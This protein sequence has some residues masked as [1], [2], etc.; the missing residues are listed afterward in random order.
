MKRATLLGLM[1]A[2]GALLSAQNNIPEILGKEKTGSTTLDVLSKC[3]V[4]LSKM[5]QPDDGFFL[6]TSTRQFGWSGAPIDLELAQQIHYPKLAPSGQVIEYIALKGAADGTAVGNP[7]EISV[8]SDIGGVPGALLATD[9]VECADNIVYSTSEAFNAPL[10][11]GQDLWISYVY[12]SD[13]MG[14]PGPRWFWG[15]TD[16]LTNLANGHPPFHVTFVD[17]AAPRF[18]PNC[19]QWTNYVYCDLY[20]ALRLFFIGNTAGLNYEF[21]ICRN[22]KLNIGTGV[23]TMTQWG[24]FIFGLV[25]LTLGVVALYNYQRKPGQESSL[26]TSRS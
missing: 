16:R 19:P 12:I 7:G 10:T 11:P 3:D 26:A 15:Q 25:V 18:G 4:P 23:P 9:V 22:A 21:N 2:F 8:W 13:P 24:L 17:A 1:M 5:V 20:D 14:N 6:L